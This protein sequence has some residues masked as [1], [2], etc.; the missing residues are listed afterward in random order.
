MNCFYFCFELS[1]EYECVSLILDPLLMSRSE[2][3]ALGSRARHI[4]IAC[5]GTSKWHALGIETW[6]QQL[7]TLIILRK[8]SVASWYMWTELLYLL[9]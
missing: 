9:D 7:T 3:S 4:E 1:V 2:V 6:R 5:S 8:S